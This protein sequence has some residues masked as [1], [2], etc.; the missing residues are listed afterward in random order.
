MVVVDPVVLR[1][2]EGRDRGW[3]K[4][5]QC[6]GAADAQ[7]VEIVQQAVVMVQLLV[8]VLVEVGREGFAQRIGLGQLPRALER[9][10]GQGNRRPDDLVLQ[11]Q[12]LGPELA[13]PRVLD[14][15]R[16]GGCQR[17]D[18]ARELPPNADARRQWIEKVTRWRSWPA[19]SKA[20]PTRARPSICSGES[21][22][23][24]SSTSSGS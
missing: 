13:Q 4:T 2:D 18:R 9:R 19:S 8:D 7:A 16:T 3:R 17:P 11:D 23:S 1:A 21:V 5:R 22:T 6:F 12:V 24:T 10:L 15:G 20:L 14:Q